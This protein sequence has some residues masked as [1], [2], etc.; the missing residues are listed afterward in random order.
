MCDAAGC[1]EISNDLPVGPSRQAKGRG[2]NVESWPQIQLG[3]PVWRTHTASNHSLGP[4]ACFPRPFNPLL[5]CLR[6]SCELGCVLEE[7]SRAA[8]KSGLNLCSGLLPWRDLT[9]WFRLALRRHQIKRLIRSCGRA[10]SRQIATQ[11]KN[12]LQQSSSWKGWTTD[13][14]SQFPKL[15]TSSTLSAPLVLLGIHVPGKSRV[16]VDGWWLSSSRGSDRWDGRGIEG[17]PKEP[18][19]DGGKGKPREKSNQE[20][21][22]DSSPRRFHTVNRAA[23]TKV[24]CPCTLKHEL[25]NPE[26]TFEHQ[27][28]ESAILVSCLWSFVY[29]YICIFST[30]R[31]VYVCVCVFMYMLVYCISVWLYV[32]IASVICS[33]YSFITVDLKIL[34]SSNSFFQSRCPEVLHPEQVK[35][36]T[37][38]CFDRKSFDSNPSTQERTV[39]LRGSEVKSEFMALQSGP[40]SMQKSKPG[41]YHGC[42]WYPLVMT[43]IAI[44]N[45]HRNSGFTDL[46]IKNGD[47]P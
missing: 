35:H 43:N 41:Y 6:R 18:A 36:L 17:C 21:K 13:G 12:L 46:P 45:G 29:I 28:L 15:Q 11:T 24:V 32:F 16:S 2:W 37:L 22:D 8:D 38:P 5:A 44:K 1:S 27:E 42:H 40:D 31:C 39:Q 3:R 7:T 47:F 10:C 4:L 33:I 9:N 34:R 19:N 14:N 20:G 23:P 25:D 30:C 26:K